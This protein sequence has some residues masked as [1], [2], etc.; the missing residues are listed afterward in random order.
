MI[1]DVV[2]LSSSV[3]TLGSNLSM[4]SCGAFLP[5]MLWLAKYRNRLPS[6]EGSCE[7]MISS[8]RAE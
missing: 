4:S 8:A 5:W 3:T 2:L 1:P 6:V 7:E